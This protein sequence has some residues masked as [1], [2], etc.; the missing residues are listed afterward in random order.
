VMVD[1]ADT[2]ADPIFD[3]IFD[4]ITAGFDHLISAEPA[5]WPAHR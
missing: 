5:D 2:P 3:P 4:P 1:M